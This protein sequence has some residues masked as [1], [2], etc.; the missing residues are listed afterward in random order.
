MTNATLENYTVWLDAFDVLSG[1]VAMNPPTDG[2]ESRETNGLI[3]DILVTCRWHFD[4]VSF[5]VA[6]MGI[7]KGCPKFFSSRSVSDAPRTKI[8]HRCF[9]VNDPI[10]ELAT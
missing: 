6:E 3:K 4:F 8:L 10:V 9:R 7:E 2:I 5:I 1:F